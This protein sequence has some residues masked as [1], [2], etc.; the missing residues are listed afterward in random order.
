[1]MK[2]R[3][4]FGLL[5][6]LVALLLVTGVTTAASAR[7]SHWGASKLHVKKFDFGGQT[8]LDDVTIEDENVVQHLLAEIRSMPPKPEFQICTKQGVPSFEFTFLNGEQEILAARG[9]I[10]GCGTVTMNDKDRR[11]PTRAFWSE[12]NGAIYAAQAKAT[13]GPLTIERVATGDQPAAKALL[14]DPVKIRH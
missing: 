9:D 14:A 4:T 2:S 5:F 11:Q 6:A 1:M 12:I 8:L 13:F 3:Y 7:Q 10:S